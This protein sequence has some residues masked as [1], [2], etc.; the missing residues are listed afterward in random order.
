VDFN[1]M[2]RKIGQ[3]G[4]D[5]MGW[6]VVGALPPLKQ[7]VAILAPH[8]SNWDFVIGLCARLALGVRIHFLGKH[9]LFFFPWGYFFKAVGGIAINRSTTTNRVDQ[10]VALFQEQEHLKLALAPE[11]TRSAVTRWKEGFYHMACQA[12][13]PIV[14]VGLDYST[15]EVRIKEPFWPTKNIGTDFEEIVAFFRTIKA[16][17]PK[18]IPDYQAKK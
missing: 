13:V 11:G 4:L 1:F 18:E 16:K 12:N 3:F 6:N 5:I 2:M 9:Q 10:I 14:M 7:Y 15:K 8:N 17:Y